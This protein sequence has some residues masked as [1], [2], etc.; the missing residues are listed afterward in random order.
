M[1]MRSNNTSAWLTGYEIITD[2][3]AKRHVESRPLEL[4]TA[5]WKWQR[6]DLTQLSPFKTVV[7]PT[8]DALI[9]VK[10]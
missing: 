2:D 8:S 5:A 1:V 10:D 4:L 9:F 3:A 6:I 7:A